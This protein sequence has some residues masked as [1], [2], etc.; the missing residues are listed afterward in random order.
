MPELDR[1]PGKQRR[2]VT[3]RNRD[4]AGGRHGKHRA[5]KHRAG[6]E[7]GQLRQQ[8]VCRLVSVLPE[9]FR[10]DMYRNKYPILRRVTHIHTEA[11]TLLKYRDDTEHYGWPGD[12]ADAGTPYRFL[13]IVSY[14]N[15]VEAGGETEFKL[16]NCK[17]KPEQGAVLVFPSGWTHEHQGLPPHS[18]SKYIITCWLRFWT[19]PRSSQLAKRSRPA[20]WLI[21]PCPHRTV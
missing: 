9:S 6:A 13:S 11:F 15:T 8:L 7:S 20:D 14:L 21:V 16:Q 10:H 3:P 17:I 4:G 2:G 19:S 12:G 18:G 1:Y 5:E